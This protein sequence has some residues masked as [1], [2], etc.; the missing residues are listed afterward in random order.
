MSNIVKN[1]AIMALLTNNAQGTKLVQKSI[2]SLK[3]IQQT[4]AQS[5]SQSTNPNEMSLNKLDG[6]LLVAQSFATADMMALDDQPVVPSLATLA[7]AQKAQATV[8]KQSWA[9]EVADE[10]NKEE[11]DAG[12]PHEL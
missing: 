1:V 4:A 12:M 2:L 6:K 10:Y 8:Q 3:D 11:D 9:Q 7:S 5:L